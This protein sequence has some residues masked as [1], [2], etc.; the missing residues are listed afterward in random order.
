MFFLDGTSPWTAVPLLVP[1]QGPAELRFSL[2]LRPLKNITV[3]HQSPM[4]TILRE[5]TKVT[6]SKSFGSLDL[7]HGYWWL[8]MDE[9]PKCLKY[10]ISPDGTISYTRVLH[11]TPNGVT[12]LKSAFEPIVTEGLQNYRIYG[13]EDTFAQNRTIWDLLNWVDKLFCIFFTPASATWILFAKA[14]NW[15]ERFITANEIRY[16]P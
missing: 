3:K 13:I 5:V 10:I 11:R 14:V 6:G 4:S 16:D 2:D 12:H 8:L 15:C 1:K 7:N 9:A